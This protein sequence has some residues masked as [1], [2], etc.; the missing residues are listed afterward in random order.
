LVYQPIK[1]GYAAVGFTPTKELWSMHIHRRQVSPRAQAFILMF[2]FHCAPWS[3]WQYRMNAAPSLHAGFF[4][5]RDHKFIVFER[6][7][8]PFTL[9]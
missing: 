9:I 5:S 2:D 4:V 1:W 7:S 3:R 6:L 8:F